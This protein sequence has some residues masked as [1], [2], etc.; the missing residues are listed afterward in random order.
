LTISHLTPEQLLMSSETPDF[1][2]ILIP[3][4]GLENYSAIQN[5]VNKNL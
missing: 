2:Y 4:L 5:Y 3:S 1:G